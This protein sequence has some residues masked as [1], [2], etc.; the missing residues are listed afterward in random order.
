MHKL[1]SKLLNVKNAFKVWNKAVFGNVQRQVKLAANEV[2]RIQNLIDVFGL[3]YDL[4]TLELEAQ[5]T[6]TRAV[7]F[8]DQFWREKARN[9][10]FM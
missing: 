2:T 4:H 3:D 7:N 6:L 1:Q 9:Q 5:L 8:Q 10:S